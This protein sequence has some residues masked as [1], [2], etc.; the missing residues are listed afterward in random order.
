MDSTSRRSLLQVRILTHLRQEPART[1]SQLAVAIN[2]Q[3]PSVSRSLNTLRS[4]GLVE[5]GRPGWTLTSPGEEEAERRSQ[6]IARLLD[7]FLPTFSTLVSTSLP[8]LNI[9]APSIPRVVPGPSFLTIGTRLQSLVTGPF[10][11][12]TQQLEGLTSGILRPF[13]KFDRIKEASAKSGWL[14]YRTIPFEAHDEEAAGDIELLAGLYSSHYETNGDLVLEDIERR[15]GTYAVDKEAKATMSEAL[16]AHG[17]G[18]YRSSCRVLLPEI[19]RILREDWLGINGIE[20]LNRR[21]LDSEVSESTM[22][23]LALD[24]THDVVTAIYI[25]EH[26]FLRATELTQNEEESVPNRHMALHGW[27]AYSSEKHSLN[28]IICAN[29]VFGIASRRGENFGRE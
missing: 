16:R 19:E 8:S 2:A 28:T 25:T 3:R 15:V 13:D 1:V 24:G 10:A 6:E 4:E 7:K 9:V 17:H 27:R 21:Q 20:A 14:P 5:R 29:Y 12:M 23:E 11:H 18:L 26:I 22:R